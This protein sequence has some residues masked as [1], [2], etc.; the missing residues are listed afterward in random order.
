LLQKLKS[1]QELSDVFCANETP[2]AMTADG[3]TMPVA[4][5]DDAAA[6][7]LIASRMC[8]V[9]VSAS[10]AA[11]Q[12][13]RELAASGRDVIDLTIGEPHFDTPE[14]IRNAAIAAMDGGQTRYTTVDGTPRLKEAIANKFVR[15]NGLKFT[16]GEIIAS[17]G[18]KQVIFNAFLSTVEEGDEVIIPSPC[19]VSYPEMTRLVGGTPIMLPC[20]EK[21]DFKLMP[22][23]LRSAITR[24]TKWLMLNSPSNPTGATYTE[25]ELRA[26]GKVLLDC[27]DVWVMSDDIYEHIIYED[28]KFSTMAAAMPELAGRTLTVN[29]VSKAYSM[30]GW[31]LGYA[32]GPRFLIK[33]MAKLQS[34]STSNPSSISQAAA[35]EALDGPQDIVL[36]HAAEFRDHRD[37]IIQELGNIPGISCRAP[38]GAFYVF[39][40]CAGV[41]GKKTPDGKRIE[42]DSDF[43]IYLLESG[44]AAIAGSSYGLSPYFRLSFATARPLLVK[45]CRRI[46]DACLKLR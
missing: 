27:P 32:G 34:Q 35:V 16:S 46:R 43:V 8:R 3:R 2:L 30:T 37:L 10:N 21:T 22:D 29:G 31:R 38:A 25:V 9:A 13:A 11:G 24:Q 5:P 36:A 20:S 12:R 39:P 19:W 23:R 6:K 1:K 7:R 33:E 41:I 14:N 40:S 18:A 42:T 28:Q 45:G 15:E 17:S 4:A 26:L 44:V